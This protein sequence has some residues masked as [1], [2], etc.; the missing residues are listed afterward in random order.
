MNYRPK[1]SNKTKNNFWQQQIGQWK[2]SGLSQKQYCLSRSIALSTFCYWKSK[3][4][5]T[6][7]STAKFYPLTISPPH[8][9]PADAGLTVLVGSKQF[10]VQIRDSFSPTTLKNLI[11][12]LEQL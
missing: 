2:S 6:D 3:I 5:K 9:Q 10:E 1:S 11:A 12:I 4:H 7:P 8:P